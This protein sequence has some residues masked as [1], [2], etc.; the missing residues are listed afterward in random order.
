MVPT[1]RPGLLQETRIRWVQTQTR[2]DAIWA[3]IK[4][5]VNG[6]EEGVEERLWK[7]W[8]VL[9]GMPEEGAAWGEEGRKTAERKYEEG[10]ERGGRAYTDA[11]KKYEQGKERAYE[12][13]ENAYKKAE[14]KM[15]DAKVKVKGT[16][17][18]AKIESEL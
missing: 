8:S 6:V 2:A 10:K 7:V 4:E 17:H 5:I 16:T 15:A 18:K 1:I 11:E 13:G 14:G 9:R 3:R 12:Q